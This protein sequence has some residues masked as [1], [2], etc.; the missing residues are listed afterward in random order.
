MPT[1]VI[2]FGFGVSG[3]V[4]ATGNMSALSFNV[5]SDQRYK[6]NIQT[7]NNALTTTKKL[8]GV[9]YNWKVEE[10]SN[11]N[12]NEAEAG[13]IDSAGSGRSTSRT[14]SYRCKWNE[15]C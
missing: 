10:F 11:K 8:R 6:K 9:T 2:M 15:V 7:L 3:D 4:N 1:V 14:G 5:T 13:R 12:F